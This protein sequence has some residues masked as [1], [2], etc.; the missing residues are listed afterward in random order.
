MLQRGPGNSV[1]SFEVI[2]IDLSPVQIGSADVASAPTLGEIHRARSM[3]LRSD[4]A[5]HR[6]REQD[7]GGQR[8]LALGRLDRRCALAHI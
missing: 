1:N 4:G 8:R 6:R 5:R 3:G 2:G 7:G